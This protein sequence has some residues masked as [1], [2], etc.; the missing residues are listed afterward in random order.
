MLHEREKLVKYLKTEKFSVSIGQAS[1]EYQSSQAGAMIKNEG[2]FDQSKNTFDQSKFQK[3][4]FFEKL[5]KITQKQLNPSNFMNEM[6]VMSLNV[7]KKHEF[8]TQNHKTRFL[9]IKNTD[10]ANP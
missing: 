8:S 2:I 6:H 4:E 9:I 3:F 10:F 7:F 5:Q 1:I